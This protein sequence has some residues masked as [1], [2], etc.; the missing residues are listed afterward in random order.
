MLKY[1]AIP[2]NRASKSKQ[3]PSSRGRRSAV[4]ASD[5]TKLP[6]APP[7]HVLTNRLRSSCKLNKQRPG[8][9]ATAYEHTIDH[10]RISD[11]HSKHDL[12]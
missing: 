12:V 7:D 4:A 2:F 8:T 11:A 9:D 3:S 6:C 1:G 10:I 5:L